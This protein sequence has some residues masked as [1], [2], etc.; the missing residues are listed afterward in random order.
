MDEVDEHTRNLLAVLE[1]I[2]PLPFGSQ[3]A[4]ESLARYGLSE[5]DADGID[6][7]FLEWEDRQ[8]P[9]GYYYGGLNDLAKNLLGTFEH[10]DEWIEARRVAML[11]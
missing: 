6:N 5:A 7:T 9:D 1:R 2:G 3:L 4:Y 10:D 11:L 8:R